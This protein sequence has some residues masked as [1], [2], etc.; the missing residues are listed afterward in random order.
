MRTNGLLAT[1]IATA[2][3]A[4]LVS[5]LP[6]AAAED[7]TAARIE[8]GGRTITV[9]AK[10]VPLRELLNRLQEQAGFTLVESSDLLQRPVTVDLEGMPWREGLAKLL[11]GF[12][13]ALAMDPETQ[14]PA[15][16]V[17]LS[18]EVSGSSVGSAS[19][20]PAGTPD[21]AVSNDVGRAPEKAESS[22]DEATRIAN[23]LLAQRENPMQ[24]AMRKAREAAAEAEAA[25]EASD[26][27]LTRRAAAGEDASESGVDRA[28]GPD[29]VY[30]D[31]LRALGQFQD[32]ERLEVLSPALSSDIKDVR[33]AA[34]EALRDGTV[35]DVAVLSEVRSMATGD[36]DPYVQRDALEV[37]VRY[38]D[39]DDVLSLVQ[40][41]GRTDGPTR[42]IAVREWL[43]I[44]KER[45]DAP[46]AN[47]QLKSAAK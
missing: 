2:L 41:L 6:L 5:A 22:M 34:L 9:T 46:L 35:S 37:Y 4:S 3:C 20:T 44:E 27:E 13:Y 17:I 47:Q 31:S 28:Q 1:V 14:Q 39:Q 29:R 30:A 12:R 25:K 21:L 26:A 8:A 15:R 19:S 18:S 10:D 45:A 42:D 11:R 33:S 24:Y 43:R 23:Q 40:S 7:T 32:S 38:G 36:S 16:L